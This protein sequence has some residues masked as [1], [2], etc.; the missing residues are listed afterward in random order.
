M[1]VFNIKLLVLREQKSSACISLLNLPIV[2]FSNDNKKW[3]NLKASGFLNW[4]GACL[5]VFE[6]MH[7]YSFKVGRCLPEG[8]RPYL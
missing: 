7:D 6:Y 8:F 4:G 1:F 3:F 2:Y 5:K